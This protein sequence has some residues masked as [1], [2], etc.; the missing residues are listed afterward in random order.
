MHINMLLM[1]HPLSPL[2]LDRSL[3]VG[4]AWTAPVARCGKCP[5]GIGLG[6]FWRRR[7]KS[8]VCVDV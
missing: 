1:L 5:L 6:T 8:H 7:R 3:L 2:P 4:F